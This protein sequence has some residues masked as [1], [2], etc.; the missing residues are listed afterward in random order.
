M[1]L[2]FQGPLANQD[3][4][5]VFTV[6][7]KNLS[8]GL[9]LSLPEDIT[10]DDKHVLL[11][12]FHLGRGAMYV[13]FT[14]KWG[15]WSQPVW[16]I[17]AL[18]YHNEEI[19]RQALRKILL[20]ADEHAMVL[21]LQ[22]GIL[23]EQGQIWLSG[24]SILDER[25]TQLATF[26]SQFPFSWTAE[27]KG[28]GQHRKLKQYGA[29]SPSHSE[30]YS[31]YML[32]RPELIRELDRNASFL[33]D[34]SGYYERARTPLAAC[35]SLGIRAHPSA[36]FV[37]RGLKNSSRDK[38]FPR[39]IYHSDALTLYGNVDIDIEMYRHGIRTLDGQ[40]AEAGNVPSG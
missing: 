40:M 3:F 30:V 31:S 29:K 18:G 16:L 1:T 6:L 28:E 11:N 14:L 23:H 22:S 27:R 20:C 17:Y 12:E 38:L 26:V 34:L 13:Y 39:V 35:E 8:S 7:G 19:G 32:R 4:T 21:A 25:C 2:T 36:L 37:V 24:V 15:H 10:L 33:S 9:F 5:D